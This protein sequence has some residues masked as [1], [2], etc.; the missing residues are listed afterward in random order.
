MKG[1]IKKDYKKRAQHRLKIIQGQISGLE[2]MVDLGFNN[3]SRCKPAD[4]Y[5]NFWEVVEETAQAK[6]N[7]VHSLEEF[8][9]L[10]FDAR[11]INWEELHKVI[12]KFPKRQ[13]L[14]KDL[15]KN[16]VDAFRERLALINPQISIIGYFDRDA[17]N[18]MVEY[19]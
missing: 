5:E 14:P 19:K 11:R 1:H 12:G 18:V 13:Y 6:Y 4:N 2:K 10:P 17:P 7:E 9:S 15:D 8:K 16:E 3:C